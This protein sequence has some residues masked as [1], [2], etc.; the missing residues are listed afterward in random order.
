[1]N[2][3]NYSIGEKAWIIQ[4]MGKMLDKGYIDL[5]TLFF[6]EEFYNLN[7]SEKKALLYA[8][9]IMSTKGYTTIKQLMININNLDSEWMCLF[10]SKNKY[11][12]RGCIK[13]I[14]KKYFNDLSEG[15]REYELRRTVYGKPK[16]KKEL[17]WKF[18]FSPKEV[19][20]DILAKKKSSQHEL[21]V[22]RNTQ[23]EFYAFLL[24]L[25][26]RQPVFIQK[27]FTDEIIIAMIQY[28][29]AL[30]YRMKQDIAVRILA[31]LMDIDIIKSPSR[32]ISTVVQ[33]Y[34]LE[35]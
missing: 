34:L 27:K 31:K 12:I 20:N 18:F 29:K 17:Q 33:A 35:N 10:K 30:P 16:K 26:E 13:D 22:Y 6:T 4:G 2:I 21:A 1:M 15:K 32:Y 7:Y 5:R 23:P 14:I 25:K 28:C 11:Y 3:L 9:Y 8:V 24:K 19:L